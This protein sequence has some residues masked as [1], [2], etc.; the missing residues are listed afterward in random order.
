M[1]RKD[2]KRRAP[3]PPMAVAAPQQPRRG[4][5]RSIAET[6]QAGLAAMVDEEEEEE[7]YAS[8]K[9]R[10]LDAMGRKPAE[11]FQRV[12]GHVAFQTAAGLREWV[13]ARR[14]AP[15]TIADLPWRKGHLAVR[16]LAEP[17]RVSIL[18]G[19]W[20]TLVV[21]RSDDAVWA[22][23]SSAE[24]TRPDWLRLLE[25]IA[26]TLQV[27]SIRRCT[28][29][30]VV[31]EEEKKKQQQLWSTVVQSDWQRFCDA[32]S[33]FAHIEVLD[34][35]EVGVDVAVDDVL[36]LLSAVRV[37]VRLARFDVAL[38]TATRAH[39]RAIA[40]L[41]LPL[42]QP[43][44]SIVYHET[45]CIHVRLPA[46]LADP[47]VEFFSPAELAR[48]AAQRTCAI[49]WGASAAMADGSKW[50]T[51]R[52]PPTNHCLLP[53][54]TPDIPRTLTALPLTAE[55]LAFERTQRTTPFRCAITLKPAGKALR[56]SWFLAAP[57]TPTQL[58]SALGELL[59]QYVPDQWWDA[60]EVVRIILHW[61]Q[62]STADGDAD[63]QASWLARH[64]ARAASAAVADSK[65]RLVPAAT[66]ADGASY[67]YLDWFFSRLM[68]DPELQSAVS[69]AERDFLQGLPRA[70]LRQLIQWLVDNGHAQRDTLLRL[71]A[72]H[73]LES[74]TSMQGLVDLYGRLT[75][76]V[77]D[78]KAYEADLRLGGVEM[79]TTVGRFLDLRHERGDE[80]PP[81]LDPARWLRP[82]PFELQ[83]PAN[84]IRWPDFT[85]PRI[86]AMAVPP[87]REVDLAT[88]EQHLI[89]ELAERKLPACVVRSSLLT[90]LSAASIAQDCPPLPASFSA[91]ST[92]VSRYALWLDSDLWPGTFAAVLDRATGAL[93]LV[94]TNDIVPPVP[95]P[96]G[97][98]KMLLLPMG[99]LWGNKAARLRL[100]R[101]LRALHGAFMSLTLLMRALHPSSISTRALVLAILDLGNPSATAAKNR[102]VA[103]RDFCCRQVLI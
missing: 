44:V 99:V 23:H 38:P 63:M 2:E 94:D 39:V 40:G 48:P 25:H 19:K 73:R 87:V 78:R 37:T 14:P 82:A 57:A 72:G 22:A 97:V 81:L 27:L 90:D 17:A 66:E 92:A 32:L 85:T 4:T 20:S 70:F 84:G 58:D 10:M 49:E 68:H 61:D 24:P 80:I 29:F 41:P 46:A 76:E 60:R 91:D 43:V 13:E 77:L 15:G 55:A 74:T 18:Y 100:D 64:R 103:Y 96:R 45:V 59:N 34:V 53:S 54:V 3:S 79:I 36:R 93:E 69:V 7:V 1:D 11:L 30:F 98:E 95:D 86:L 56:G 67:V 26:P 5:K 89:H 12:A 16:A 71:T 102:L 88:Y 62:R 8:A 52:R 65:V 47:P 31:V 6:V 75:F 51:I 9:R 33:W 42:A 28:S 83:P 21:D 50:L 35:G 101:E